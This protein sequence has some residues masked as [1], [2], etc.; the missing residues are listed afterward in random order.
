[1]ALSR[2]QIDELLKSVS[3]TRPNEVN[4]DQC[5]DDLAEFAERSLAGKSIPDSLR[6][7]EHHLAIC[8]ECRE[9]YQAL[10]AALQHH[11]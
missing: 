8:A 2:K 6:A 11:H 7:V 3:L 10:L 9:E 1:M 5:L 4:C